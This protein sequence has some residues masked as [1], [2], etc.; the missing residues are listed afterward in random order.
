MARPR[1]PTSPAAAADIMPPTVTIQGTDRSMPPSRITSIAPVAM[2][3]RKDAI[4][5]CSSR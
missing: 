3:P 2:T 1:R 5:S 4:C